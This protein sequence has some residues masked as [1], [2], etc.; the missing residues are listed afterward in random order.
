MRTT[1]SPGL[2]IQPQ[3]ETLGATSKE[4]KLPSAA[5]SRLVSLD[6]F[7]GFTMFLLIA[8]STDIYDLLVSPELNGTL[9][10]TIGMQFH[11]HPWN[12]LRFWDLI[13]PFFMFI[14]GV[15]M[16]F[17]IGG[18]WELG[19]SWSATFRHA[20][21]RSF[22]L[23]LFVWALYCIGP[24][25][26]TFE[27]WNVLAQLSFTYLV[28]FLMMRQPIPLQLGF[29]LVLLAISETAYRLCP[30]PGFNEPFVPD[31]NFGS[32]VDLLLMGKLSRG[33]WVAFNA[34]PTTAHTMWGVI[35]GQVLKSA[36]LPLEK[37]KLLVI[38]G[39]I[40]VI[41]GYAL[42]PVTPIIKRICTSSF[43]IASG[44]WCLLALALSY[45]LID[46]KKL[47][48][49]AQFLCYVGM[50][51]LFIYLFTET[52]GANWLARIVKPFAMGIFGWAGQLSANIVSSLTVWAL[53]WYLCY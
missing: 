43:V 8:E 31:R 30:V 49:W 9:I 34:V 35:A 23:L 10:S 39:L 22:L 26:I 33:Y 52:G 21:Q 41:V 45:W 11:H 2:E 19:D 50:N 7:R 13:Q 16:P 24:G 32:Y 42:N 18:R 20:L 44:G 5:Q 25:K 36:R 29:T 38:S 48:S 12:G 14:V 27:L 47:Q 28:A 53:L 40:G 6:F 51:S 1:Q 3:P 46:V 37:I 15:A 17:S 4:V